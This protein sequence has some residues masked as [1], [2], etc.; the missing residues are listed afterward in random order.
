MDRP[1][2]SI[3]RTYPV[4]AQRVYDAWTRPELMVQWYCPN[5]KLPLRAETDVRVGGAW[6]LHMDQMVV[7]GV[8]TDVDSPVVVAFT[9]KWDFDSGPGSQVRVE[10][11]PADGGTRMVLTHSQLE[12]AE[13]VKNHAE[14]WEGSLARLPRLL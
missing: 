9:W 5:P 8:Y 7:R 1:E 6:V 14:G 11:S 3:E 4:P 12:D 13:D 2:L 10:L